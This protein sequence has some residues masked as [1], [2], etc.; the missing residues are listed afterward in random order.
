MNRI[1]GVL[2]A[3]LALGAS[4]SAVA[5]NPLGAYVGFGVGASNVGNNNYG[6]GYGY[7]CGP[8]ACYGY[9]G[10][11][12]TNVV[13]WKVMA[14]IRPLPI[15]GAELEYMD[16]GSANGNNGYYN[17]YYYSGANTHPKATI[18]YGVGYLPLPLP[19]LDVFGKVGVARLQTNESAYYNPTACPLPTG[20]GCSS[21][22]IAG[23]NQT[24]DKF[25]YG[26]GVQARWQDFAFRAEYE[27]VSSEYGNPAAVSISVTWTF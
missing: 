20:V 16:F 12:G 22:L 21:A 13:S 8:Y 11:Y 27:G 10:N 7:G 19:Y 26:A 4:G 17:N 6:N 9:G 2:L 15:V 1:A 14:G 24:N 5:G 3:I 18:L 23:I 25:A